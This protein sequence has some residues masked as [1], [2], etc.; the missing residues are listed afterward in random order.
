MTPSLIFVI[1]L[2]Y[3]LILILLQ[4]CEFWFKVLIFEREEWGCNSIR[5]QIW[6]T[7]LIQWHAL[8]SDLCFLVFV[9]V[10]NTLLLV[11]CNQWWNYVKFND[12]T[13]IIIITRSPSF[14]W[15]C[16]FFFFGIIVCVIV[17]DLPMVSDVQSLII[18]FGHFVLNFLINFLDWESKRLDN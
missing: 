12:Y 8:P 1:D 17:D 5:L 2:P 14:G 13:M 9:F 11:V 4:F 10:F 7:V 18:V 16:C 3:F 6:N 15:D